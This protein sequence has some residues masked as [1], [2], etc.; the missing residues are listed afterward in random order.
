[1]G[2]HFVRVKQEAPQGL[3]QPQQVWETVEV[4]PDG[5]VDGN[6]IPP[7]PS[8]GKWDLSNRLTVAQC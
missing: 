1:M 2:D 6:A 5:A 3:R 7:G 8:Q 4:L